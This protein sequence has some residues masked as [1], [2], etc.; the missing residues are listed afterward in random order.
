[1][2]SIITK[3]L[4]EGFEFNGM[5]YVQQGIQ[6]FS[7][8]WLNY[9]I[10]AIVSG[11][12]TV[13]VAQVPMGGLLL[14][15]VIT[16]LISAG[17]YIVAEKIF[18]KE[19]TTLKDFLGGTDHLGGLALSTLL[20]GLVI[21]GIM[22]VLMML[23]LIP[24]VAIMKDYDFSN[25]LMASGAL[26]PI[27]GLVF[28]TV[29]IITAVYTWYIFTYNYVIFGKMEGS[30]AMGVS[31]K[32]VMKQY[33]AIFLFV[34]LLSMLTYAFAIT[35][36]YYTGQFDIF[37]VMFEAMINRD[38]DVLQN[39]K[40]MVNLPMQLLSTVLLSFIQPIYHCIVQAAFHDINELDNLDGGTVDNTVEHLV[41]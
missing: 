30:E 14:A 17:Y 39:L 22:I 24:V 18:R 15:F 11:I 5:S 13:L 38:M 34:F 29:F 10:F 35:V 32:I 2:Q 4:R 9:M 27:I 25:G 23:M 36:M 26:L 31:R 1:M 28:M 12:A 8:N 19:T 7:S 21:V 6:N 20:Q 37:K 3:K 33:V 41:G 40:S 16:P